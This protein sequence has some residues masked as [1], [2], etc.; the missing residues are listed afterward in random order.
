[1]LDQ[2]NAMGATM[3]V[4]VANKL[5]W[6]GGCS[7]PTTGPCAD[8]SLLLPWLCVMHARKLLWGQAPQEPEARAWGAR[9][10]GGATAPTLPQQASWA[11]AWP[12]GVAPGN[13]WIFRG[14]R[15]C[16][17]VLCGSKLH[18]VDELCCSKVAR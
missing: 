14:M 13:Q 9:G 6:V 4:V 2:A 17:V 15:P 3:L 8:G 11:L 12:Q 7:C 1:M 18:F 16:T 10:R 5:W